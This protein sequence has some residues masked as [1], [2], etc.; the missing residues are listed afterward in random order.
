MFLY[1]WHFSI[2]LR[3]Q[4][5]QVYFKK[6]KQSFFMV[7]NVKKLKNITRKRLYRYC[8]INKC[9]QIHGILPI[10]LLPFF[11]TFLRILPQISWLTVSALWWK[12]Q[13]KDSLP[14]PNTHRNRSN[15]NDPSSLQAGRHGGVSALLIFGREKPPMEGKRATLILFLSCLSHMQII[16]SWMERSP[17]NFLLEIRVIS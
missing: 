3:F 14:T 9:F 13:Q 10:I 5:W 4:E 15:E 12:G 11:H 17:F 6:C 8:Y 7:P 16:E 2:K 1:F